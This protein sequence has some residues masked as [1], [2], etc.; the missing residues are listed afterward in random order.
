[1]K[2]AAHYLWPR[3]YTLA[4]EARIRAWHLLSRTDFVSSVVREA[5]SKGIS[6][7]RIEQ[8]RAKIVPEYGKALEDGTVAPTIFSFSL[9][10]PNFWSGSIDLD[11]PEMDD[12]FT[13]MTEL[14]TANVA[15]ARRRGIHDG[16][17]VYPVEV[18]IRPK[19]TRRH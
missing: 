8:W 5:T 11:S 9:I 2:A 18:S 16:R 12:K 15:D 7:E 1:M 4:S 6:A 17:R 14:L 10:V 13:K 19:R 3:I